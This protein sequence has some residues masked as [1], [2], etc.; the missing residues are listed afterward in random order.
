MTTTP[1]DQLRAA[2]VDRYRLEREFVVTPATGLEC[3]LWRFRPVSGP[4]Q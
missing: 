2:L 3:A 1:V 4:G